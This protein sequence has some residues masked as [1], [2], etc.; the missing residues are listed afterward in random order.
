MG[1]LVSRPRK[2]VASRWNQ[3]PNA[4]PVLLHCSMLAAISVMLHSGATSY[5]GRPDA[6]ILLVALA[7][8]GE[9]QTNI[10]IV[11]Q[12]ISLQ[13]E[14]RVERICSVCI[15]LVG[16]NSWQVFRVASCPLA[17]VFKES[18]GENWR[19]TSP[20]RQDMHLFV[21]TLPETRISC[22]RN[23]LPHITGVA[24]LA[25]HRP[26]TKRASICHS[27]LKSRYINIFWLFLANSLPCSCSFVCCSYRSATLSN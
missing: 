20:P 26:R 2:E 12:T 3:L 13:S 21:S 24:C 17:I 4:L 6:G 9:E 22:L 14:A 23:V 7:W 10:R 5:F 16:Q 27:D 1:A 18:S 15:G 11:L 25:P 19:A 8:F